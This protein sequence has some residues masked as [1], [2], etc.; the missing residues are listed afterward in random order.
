MY[1]IRTHFLGLVIFLAIL[2][3]P[4]AAIASSV[5]FFESALIET[6]Q[7]AVKKDYARLALEA[8]STPPPPFEKV[9]RPTAPELYSIILRTTGP[10][11]AIFVVFQGDGFAAERMAVDLVPLTSQ[12]FTVLVQDY[13]GLGKSTGTPSFRASVE[14]AHAWIE[15]IRARQSNEA[16]PIV[17]YGTSFGG[18]ALLSALTEIRSNEIVVLD[19]VPDHLPPLL[20]CRGKYYPT[21]AIKAIPGIDKVKTRL[22]VVSSQNDTKAG[23]DAMSGLLKYASR[24]GATSRVVRGLAH[25]FEDNDDVP[26]RLATILSLIS[27]VLTPSPVGQTDAT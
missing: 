21:T 16:Q 13:R 18:V 3:P 23:P 15:E 12:G 9:V 11:R 4:R 10:S 7:D 24:I 22:I 19:G 25:P 17:Y 26:S 14:D 1:E 27:P 6:L 20:L 2:L 5:C 8:A